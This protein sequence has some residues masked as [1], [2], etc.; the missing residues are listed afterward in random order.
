MDFGIVKQIRV[1]PKRSLAS[2]GEPVLSIKEIESE[3]KTDSFALR[4]PS[5]W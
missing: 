5:L 3:E 2:E 4:H 1:K